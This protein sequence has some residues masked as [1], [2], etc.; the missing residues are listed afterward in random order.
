MILPS[1]EAPLI[2]SSSSYPHKVTHDPLSYLKASNIF[3][4]LDLSFFFSFIYQRAIQFYS[5]LMIFYCVFG[6][7]Y[8]Q[9]FAGSLTYSTVVINFSG[10]NNNGSALWISWDEITTLS[11]KLSIVT[12]NALNWQPWPFNQSKYLFYSY[13]FKLSFGTILSYAISLSNL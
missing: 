13:L 4:F 3:V 7:H 8:N 5:F 2:T 9:L 10:I 12:F 6:F 1:K 11:T